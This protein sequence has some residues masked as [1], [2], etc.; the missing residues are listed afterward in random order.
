MNNQLFNYLVLKNKN[1]GITLVEIL[2]IITIIGI[3]SAIAIP[4]FICRSPRA[5]VSE[6]KS[7]LSAMNRAQQSYFI[8][9]DGKFSNSWSKLGVGIPE[10]TTNYS[11]YTKVTTNAVFN[12]GIARR[13]Y[14]EDGWFNKKPLKSVIGGVFVISNAKKSEKTTL[15]VVCVSEKIGMIIPPQPILKNGVPTCAIGTT[16]K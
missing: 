7:Y 11:Y 1:Q 8:E 10:K 13:E 14:V 16:I 3:L 15:S 5:I 12:Y 6:A 4:S 9:S 2:V